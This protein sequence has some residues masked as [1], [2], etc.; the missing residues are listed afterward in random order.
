MTMPLS[1]LKKVGTPF[2]RNCVKMEAFQAQMEVKHKTKEFSTMRGEMI[3]GNNHQ[4]K[5]RHVRADHASALT[6]LYKPTTTLSFQ[7]Q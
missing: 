3:F 2:T 4:K 1:I 6:F 7:L 5:R